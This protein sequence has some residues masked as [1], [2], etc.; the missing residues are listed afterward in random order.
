MLR[1]QIARTWQAFDHAKR[2]TLTGVEWGRRLD[3]S[4]SADARPTLPGIKNSSFPLHYSVFSN[5]LFVT[6]DH[7]T[8]PAL[9]TTTTTAYNLRS[10]TSVF[11]CFSSSLPTTLDHPTPT[12][13]SN[14]GKILAMANSPNKR[15]SSSSSNRS[16]GSSM[17]NVRASAYVVNASTAAL[18]GFHYSTTGAGGAEWYS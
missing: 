15:S 5:T 3:P 9:T 18:S 2:Q 4:A 14:R 17:A 8:Q 1:R 7:Q 10:T 13:S 16:S 11:N 12:P 6:T